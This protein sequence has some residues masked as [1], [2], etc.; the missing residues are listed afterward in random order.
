[1]AGVED[2]DS[3]LESMNEGS[4]DLTPEK[5]TA[6][7]VESLDDDLDEDCEDETLSERLWGLTEMFPEGLRNKT[8]SLCK[9][10]QNLVKTLYHYSRLSAWIFFSSSTILVAPIIFEIERCQMEEV[11]K[12]QQKQA[13]LGPGVAPR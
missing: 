5:I 11:Q 6:Q 12:Y 13:L 8:H 7:L 2:L 1:M 4:K 3:G 9:G 10:S